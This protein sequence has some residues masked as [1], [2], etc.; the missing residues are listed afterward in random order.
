VTYS[1]VA[2]DK[3][4][5]LL[6]V[7]V[8]SGSLAVGSRVPWAKAGIG[9]VATQ[10]HTN[11]ALGPLILEYL[12]QGLKAREALEKALATDK[13]PEKRQ[14]AVV[15]FYG[16]VA[17]HSGREIPEYNDVFV[18]DAVVCLG[19]LVMSKEIPRAMCEAYDMKREKDFVWALLSALAAG[20]N[21]GGDRRKDRSGA[22]IV[23]GET[24]YG[25]Y[26]DYIVNLRVDYSDNPL[27]ELMMLYQMYKEIWF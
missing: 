10:A 16:N 1:I 3:R 12:S 7:A 2:L 9:A 24:P 26:Y 25:K 14:V 27:E 19:N 23:V 13:Y 6:G 21:L 15:D 17:Y 4:R 11:P 8:I 5:K 22:L 20:H 18:G